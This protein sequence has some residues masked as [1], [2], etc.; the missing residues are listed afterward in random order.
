VKSPTMRWKQV[1]RWVVVVHGDAPPSDEDW[2]GYVDFLREAIVG[3][4]G[5]VITDGAGPNGRQREQLVALPQ[6]TAA[7]FAVVTPSAVARGI[8]TAL[9]W[10][11]QSIKAFSPARIDDALQHLEVPPELRPWMLKQIASLRTELGSGARSDDTDPSR[12]A[13]PEG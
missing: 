6:V 13:L 5:L 2:D 9:G 1:D 12:R 11:G 4:R 3:R 7:P 10:L 8:V